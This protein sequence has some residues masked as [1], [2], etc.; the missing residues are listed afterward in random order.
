M[1]KELEIPDNI[2]TIRN[3]LKKQD[4]RATSHP[5]YIVMC[6]Y[7]DGDKNVVDK[8]FTN[9]CAKKRVKELENELEYSSIKNLK[10]YIYVESG[11]RNPEWIAI[12]DFI[13]NIESEEEKRNKHEILKL[14][15]NKT[16]REKIYLLNEIKKFS[17]H[18]IDE[19]E[20]EFVD[21]LVEEE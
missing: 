1:K 3:N 8:F 11:W 4:V 20:R 16:T 17:A 14:L 10:Y 2:M 5:A 6:E 7:G 18:L 15:E 21:E 13:M 12:R 19:Y 9:A